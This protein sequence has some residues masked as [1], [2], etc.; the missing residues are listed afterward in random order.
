MIAI[1]YVQPCSPTQILV[2][3]ELPETAGPLN[4]EETGSFPAL[5]SAASLDQVVLTHHPE[6][7]LGIDR[8]PEPAAH[9]R[10]DHPHPVP[11]GLIVERLLDNHPLD[12]IADR[13]PPGHRSRL[14]RPIQRL[15]THPQH[16]RHTRQ[17]IPLGDQT[18]RPGDTH[19]HSQPANAFPAISSSYVL[20]PSARSSSATFRRNSRSPWRSCFPASCLRAAALKQLLPPRVKERLGD[21]VLPA[22]VPGAAIAAQGG[23]HDLDLLL[24]RPAPILPLL[25]QP[26]FSSGRATDAEPDAGQSLRRYAPPGPSDH[27]TQLAV[28]T[29]TG[30]RADPPPPPNRQLLP[31]TPPNRQNQ[32]RSTP[33]YQTRPRPLLLPT[34]PRNTNPPLDNIEASGSVSRHPGWAHGPGVPPELRRAR[35]RRLY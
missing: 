7:P 14:R 23:Q 24:R 6:H 26:I 16:A 19:A 21:L 22:D 34:P 1:R 12:W 20:G 31:T 35:A 10:A 33:L 4:P 11:V 29:P 30:S 9:K 18:A 8:H 27:P 17:R 28:N 5:Q 2:N 25:A 15:P 13:A 32:Q 3:V